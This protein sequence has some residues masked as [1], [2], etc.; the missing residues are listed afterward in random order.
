MGSLLISDG[1]EVFSVSSALQGNESPI[2][3]VQADLCNDADRRRVVEVALARFERIDVI[4]NAA[5]T[6][7]WGPIIGSSRVLDSAESQFWLNVVVPLQLAAQVANQAWRHT[8]DENAIRRR[9]VLNISSIGGRRLI[10]SR[11]LGK[12]STAQPK[13][14]SITSPGT[15]V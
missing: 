1:S 9:H 5:A 15:C 14:R 4:I 2:Y 8:P 3:I 7:T 11:D 10:T 6:S 12:G 13:R